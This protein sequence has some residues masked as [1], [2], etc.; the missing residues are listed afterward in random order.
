MNGKL[1]SSDVK[2]ETPYNIPLLI[3]EN[4]ISSGISDPALAYLRRRALQVIQAAGQEETAYR[5]LMAAVY[6]VQGCGKILF[7]EWRTK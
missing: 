7:K 1:Q 2:N 4:V 3:N 5:Q 6:T